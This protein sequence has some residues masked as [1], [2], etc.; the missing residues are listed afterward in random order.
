VV[1]SEAMTW[2]ILQG[3]ISVAHQTYFTLTSSK[4][5]CRGV[6]VLARSFR[7]TDLDLQL[8]CDN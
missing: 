3:L 5:A 4:Y 1:A 7:R 2:A 8:G 6:A